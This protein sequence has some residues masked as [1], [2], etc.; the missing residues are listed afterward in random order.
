[1]I[2]SGRKPSDSYVRPARSLNST[3]NAAPPARISTTVPTC[4]RQ[5]LYSG[6]S[7][8][9]ATTSSSLIAFAIQHLARSQ[10]IASCQARDIRTMFDNPL[11]PY[12]HLLLTPCQQKVYRNPLSPYYHLLLTP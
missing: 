11:S 2:C 7:T 5:R 3:S 12:Y 10:R 6:R 1:M 9:S 4:P 8:V